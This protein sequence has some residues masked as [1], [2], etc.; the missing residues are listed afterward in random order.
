MAVGAGVILRPQRQALVKIA[1]KAAAIAVICAAGKHHA[2]KGE[3]GFLI[4]IGGRLHSFIFHAW[5][6]SEGPLEGKERTDE[7]EDAREN[8]KARSGGAHV[9][10]LRG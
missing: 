3:F 4:P 6:F 9:N 1:V 5:I 7:G 2:G 8:E 10:L